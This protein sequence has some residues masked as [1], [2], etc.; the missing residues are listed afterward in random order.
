MSLC[1]SQV[2][3]NKVWNR[4][5]GETCTDFDLN[6]LKTALIEQHTN[7]INTNACESS[8]L[9]TELTKLVVLQM[10][11]AQSSDIISLPFFSPPMVFLSSFCQHLNNGHLYAL[12]YQTAIQN[13]KKVYEKQWIPNQ[14]NSLC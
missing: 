4:I 6:D 5:M 2:S 1:N 7:V 12:P 11:K 10:I 13:A 3:L 14:I 8:A 9:T